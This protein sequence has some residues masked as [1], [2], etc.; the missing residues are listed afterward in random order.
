MSTLLGPLPT[1]GAAPQLREP[2]LGYQ[3]LR[4]EA[5]CCVV[6]GAGRVVLSRYADV[7]TALKHPGLR[8]SDLLGPVMSMPKALQPVVRPA[9]RT[10]S[11][12]MLFTDPPDHTRLRGLANR[13]FTPR[14][15]EAMRARVEEI[16]EGLLDDLRPAGPVDLMGG[17]A[18]WLPVIVIAEMLGTAV[19]DLRK[20][21]RWSDD[22][23]LLVSS[24]GQPAPVI[25]SRGAWAV[26]CLQKYLRRLVRER[27]AKPGNNLLDAMIA[28]EESGDVLTEQELVS[29]ALLLLVAGHITTTHLIGSGV[30]A[31]LQHPDQL[32]LVR[33]RPELMPSAV[34]EILRY[35]SPLQFTGRFTPDAVEVNGHRIPAGCA[36]AL[37][38]GSANHDPEQ[39]AEPE[40]LDITRPDNRHLAFAAG[41]HFCL[42]AALARLEGQVAIGAV[43]RRFPKLRL[44]SERIEW[45]KAGAQRGLKRLMVTL[46]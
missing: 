12:M 3:R 19:D 29:N 27:R 8:M 31:L 18:N 23:A 28:A 37:C 15:V 20:F 26:Y 22:F 33:A 32:E 21:K 36:V 24:S 44:A 14:A 7:A 42:G 43:L 10:I 2:Y 17:F 5:P 1:G 45:R 40:R 41:A 39:F 6:P 35:E 13:A 34:E 16:A 25:A 11:R 46:A 9:A 30:L 38:L 4:E